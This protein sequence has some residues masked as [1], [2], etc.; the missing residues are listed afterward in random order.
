[1]GAKGEAESSKGGGRGQGRGKGARERADWA[2]PRAQGRGREQQS[3]RSTWWPQVWAGA[4]RRPGTAAGGRRALINVSRGEGLR[5][6]GEQ[7]RRDVVK[8]VGRRRS[9]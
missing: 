1:M 3:I 5:R 7:G 8:D 6:I 2:E 4:Y 9:L